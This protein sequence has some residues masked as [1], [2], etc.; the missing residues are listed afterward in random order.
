METILSPEVLD[1]F[2][3]DIRAWFADRF[4]APTE[5][6][7]RAWP[8]IAAGQSA[9]LAAPT[10][11]GKTLAAFLWALDRLW[12]RGLEGELPPH[13]LVLYVSPLKALSHDVKKN[14]EEPL[15]EIRRR[16][17]L[18]H[19]READI[20]VAVRTGDTPAAEREQMRR[21][22]PHLLI[23]TP[24]SLFLLLTS[25]RGRDLL[26]TVETVIVDE[27]HALAGNR[28]GAHL[29]LS[30]ERLET[31]VE[32]PL[33]RIG[34]SATQKPLDLVARFLTGDRGPGAVVIDVGRRRH[35]DL[36]VEL[37]PAGL[38]AVMSLEI[39]EEVYARLLALIAE[40]RTTL[41]FVSTRRLAERVA[42]R[43]RQS[44]GD[45][46]VA[47]HHGSM[48]RERRLDAEQRLKNGGLKA[49]AATSSLE[50]GIDI[51]FVDLVVQIGSPRGL[52][53]FLQRAGRSRHHVGGV[54]KARIF[55]L[56]SSE[57]V[58]HAA[59]LR[60]LR[61]GELDAL[62]VPAAPLDILSQQ[63]VAEAGC[64]EWR[65]DD[66]YAAFRHAHPYRDL[67]RPRFDEIVRLA[68]QGYT[69]R[70][71]RRGA[72]L[73]LDAVNGRLRGRPG[74]RLT[75]LLNGGAIPDSFD[76]EVRL[77][78]GDQFLGTVNEDFA[79]E[80]MAGDV[81]LL[82]NGTWRILRVEENAVRVADAQGEAP[83]LPF[84]LGEAPSR[85]TE[86]SAAV[87]DLRREIEARLGD[88]EKLRATVAAQGSGSDAAWKTP[89]AAWLQAETG[90]LPLAANSVIEYLASA[91]LA[92]GHLPTCETLVAERFFDAG[93]D[94]HLVLH[95]PY[96]GRVNRAFG[97]ALRKRF[98]RKFNFELQA[99]ATEEGL[100]LSLGV[101]HSFPLEDVFQY[102]RAATVRDL[103]QQ[104]VLDSPMFEVRWRWNATRFLALARR[105]GGR[106]V[107]PIFQRLEAQ[108]LAAL[109]FPDQ[110]ACAE[111]L[112]GDRSIPDHPLVRQTLD[113]CLHEAMDIDT[114]EDLL[115]RIE[116]GACRC[117]AVD[118]SEPSP[119]AQEL[120]QAR[121][122]AF[123]DGAPLEERRTRAVTARA[124]DD[125]ARIAPAA[126]DAEAVRAVTAEAR[127]APR[128]ADE[129]HDVL[130]SG[131]LTEGEIRA[132]KDQISWWPW[133]EE[134][135]RDRRVGSLAADG[136][137]PLWFAAERLA[138]ARA[139]WPD[140]APGFT[141]VLPAALSRFGGSVEDAR[142][143][144]IRGR[145]ESAGPASEETLAAVT[146][147]RPEAVAA[148]LAALESEGFAF[149]G[150][151]L[152]GTGPQWCE[153]RLLFR[154]RQRSVAHRRRAATTVSA[155]QFQRF[156]FR[157][158]GV[159]HRPED[160]GGP[161]RL[162]AE[163]EKLAGFEAPADLWE[164]E[165]LPARIP[166]YDPA[167]LDALCQSGRFGFARLR[168]PG[169]GPPPP[170][171]SL[172]YLPVAFF[173]RSQ[174]RWWRHASP[175]PL[176]VTGA[177]A[178]LQ[179]LLRQ[180]GASFADDLFA[181]ARLLPEDAERGLRVLLYAG[182]ATSD[183]F[184]GWR[185]LA[186]PMR[187]PRS[188]T[189]SGWRP[190]RRIDTLPAG[191]FFL[192]PD[193]AER[194][195]DENA[196]HAAHTLLNRYGVVFRALAEREPGLPPW[197][198]LRRAL[199]TLEDRG[200]AR[201]GRFVAGPSGEQ[202]A[203]PDALERLSADGA[204]ET[205]PLLLAATDPANLQG[206][207]A[208]ERRVPM[209]PKHRVL[210]VNGV[211]KLACENHRLRALGSLE[212]E[213]FES[214]STW[215]RARIPGLHSETDVKYFTN[216][217]KI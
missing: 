9:L 157:W 17:L 197:R 33:Q 151:Y 32:K 63:I 101:T 126:L 19:V 148:A 200:E 132:G 99:A 12:R 120:L 27:V 169:E 64:R 55:P 178:E 181:E 96:G 206:L 124:A 217:T 103:L 66:L 95:S 49:L 21:H 76:Y 90:L 158:Q 188:R 185:V 10:G 134:L 180:R 204:D 44:L 1:L 211:P 61:R 203:A 111:N 92:L 30:L 11:S 171:L 24:E 82:G 196:L 100:I 176:Q 39:W 182:L 78:P 43:L 215:L 128:D 68:A 175:A 147:W 57:L 140:A 113:D 18:T 146:G 136:A 174:L 177:A 213:E 145:L 115:R 40:H 65:L 154:M 102:L 59:L 153:R 94:M 79:I 122:Y 112:T 208:P 22:P 108:D 89:A 83:S 164:K 116:S 8:H 88:A 77:D 212:A 170:F 130:S 152:A 142:R 156:L 52:N 42:H 162:A 73:H 163:L 69:T 118:V 155:A 26:K 48:S 216:R 192:L 184:A 75:A 50:L 14:L 193:A 37:P 56:T 202:F 67:P 135:R 207:L 161:D 93:G 186:R 84:W 189:S 5:A 205:S 138:E 191:R 86:L 195:D 13:T 179:A 139:A 149:R 159:W 7:T 53:P 71:G 87:S 194:A 110:L 133:L 187:A 173:P 129:L 72:H 23:T 35:F 183:N 141:P 28:R 121:P 58:E 166:G 74:A 106:R 209:Q 98:C 127:P 160:R 29:A 172:R 114:L 201:G 70:R 143:E 131:F 4:G 198:L 137:T 6:Q 210:F 117:L 91:L 60:A 20:S 109:V 45:D 47:A 16:S 105:R 46:A 80:S 25:P 97:L 125:P 144:M 199:R 62:Q 165:I 85:S 81:F 3:A 119:L 41:I 190:A 123:L 51:G 168:P 31:L 15:A 54:P 167:W 150:E 2:H 36:Q 104:A 34:L 107:P 214:L 38:S